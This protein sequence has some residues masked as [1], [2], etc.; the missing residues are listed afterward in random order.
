MLGGGVEGG[1]GPFTGGGG[2]GGGGGGHFTDGCVV[3]VSKLTDSFTSGHYLLAFGEERAQ[4]DVGVVS[5]ARQANNP[6]TG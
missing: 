3:V 2:G 5:N 4:V 1:G 6:Y